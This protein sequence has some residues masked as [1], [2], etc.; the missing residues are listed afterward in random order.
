MLRKF[1]FVLAFSTC[2]RWS[3]S[4]Q[5]DRG[6]FTASDFDEAE[7]V[8]TKALGTIRRLINDKN[9]IAF[10]FQ[11]L[12]EVEEIT[13]GSPIPVQ[14][15]SIDRLKDYEPASAVLVDT[16]R[17]VF[18]VEYH[19]EGRLLI[20]VGYQNEK[21]ELISFGDADIAGNLTRIRTQKMKGEVDSSS[22]K[23]L[24]IPPMQLDFMEYADKNKKNLKV[25]PLNSLYEMQ[26]SVGFAGSGFFLSNPDFTPERGR[27]LPIDDIFKAL[28]PGAKKLMLQTGPSGGR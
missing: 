21:W 24:R 14:T 2:I 26:R 6:S 28:A 23:L 12:S 1:I 9:Y 18:P 7:P 17:L 22:I 16:T 15:A 19:G 20:T 8:A 27:G 11:S 25:V 13:L 3:G 10:G 4:A 5:P